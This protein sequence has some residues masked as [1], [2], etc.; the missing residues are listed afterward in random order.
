MINPKTLTA[1]IVVVRYTVLGDQAM[2][3]M[4]LR[5]EYGEYGLTVNPSKYFDNTIEEDL[6]HWCYHS[7]QEMTL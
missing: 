5:N 3:K 4:Y 2:Y 6:A 7:H 1:P